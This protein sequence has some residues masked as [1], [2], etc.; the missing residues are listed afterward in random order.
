[1]LDILGLIKCIIRLC[2]HV[3]IEN[4]SLQAYTKLVLTA[5]NHSITEIGWAGSRDSIPLC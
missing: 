5:V 3:A 4:L 2:F 1:M